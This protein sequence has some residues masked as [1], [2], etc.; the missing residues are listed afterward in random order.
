MSMNNWQDIL[1]R[2]SEN[3]FVQLLIGSFVM[4][5]W[6]VISLETE[7]SVVNFVYNNF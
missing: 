4:I 3:Y 6:A 7:G 1:A 2:F 5:A